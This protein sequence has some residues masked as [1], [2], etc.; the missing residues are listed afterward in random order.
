MAPHEEV[1]KYGALGV[2][3]A[4]AIGAILFSW[5]VFDRAYK[6]LDRVVGALTQSASSQYA[7]AQAVTRLVSEVESMADAYKDSKLD[8]RT[9]I[10]SFAK[11]IRK[12]IRGCRRAGDA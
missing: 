6:Q 10:E 7:M 1:L 4:L 12:D 9:M 8:T 2:A 5:K 3:Y 11:E